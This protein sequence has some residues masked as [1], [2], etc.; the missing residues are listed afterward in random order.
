MFL[1]LPNPTLPTPPADPIRNGDR[2]MGSS[3]TIIVPLLTRITDSYRKVPSLFW[4]SSPEAT[5]I[6]LGLLAATE[7]LNPLVRI[8]H[9]AVPNFN[10]HIPNCGYL[11]VR[12]SISRKVSI[13]AITLAS[14]RSSRLFAQLATPGPPRTR[15]GYRNHARLPCRPCQ[16][17]PKEERPKVYFRKRDSSRS[18]F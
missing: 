2:Y 13:C 6:H 7:E 10:T 15:R 9:F 1:P 16:L 12:K 8:R 4:Q 11:R 3:K 17:G 14:R 5:C 18:S